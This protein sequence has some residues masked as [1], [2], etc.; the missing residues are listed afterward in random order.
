MDY[1][2]LTEFYESLEKTAKRL[3]KV[4]IIASLLETIQSDDLVVALNLIQGRVFPKTEEK[5]IG[6]SSQLMK[7]AIAKATGAAPESI[8]KLLIKTGD[9]GI[10]AEQLIKTKTQ[11]TLF[12]SRLTLN[13][14]YANITRLA[15]MEGEGTVNKKVSVIAELLTSAK[16]NEARFI[17]RTILENLRVGVAEGTMRDA[18]VWAFFAKELGIKYNRESNEVEIESREKYNEYAGAV[19]HLYDVTNDFVDV[20]KRLKQGGISALK[21]VEISLNKPINV[22]LYKKAE[23]IADAF[24]SVG[25]PCAL[26]YKYDGFRMLLIRNQDETRL[27]T[28]RL[29]NVTRQFPDV[30]RILRE[31]INSRSYVLDSEVIGIDPK[32]RKWLPFQQI[33]QR[34]RRKYNIEEMER[35]VPVMVN[36]FDAVKV[37]GK[38]LINEPFRKRR[39]IIEK[40]VHPVKDR[41]QPAHQIVTDNIKEAEKFYKKALKLGNEGIMA[42]NLEGIYKPG[43]RVGYGVKIKPTLES[44]DLVITRAEWGEGKRSSWFSS[45]TIS[46]RNGSEFLEI[47]RV[48]T[49]IKEL[50]QEENITFRQ[51]TRLL[52]PLIIEKQGKEVAI[53]PKIIVEVAYEEIQKSPKYSSGFALRFPRVAR[54]RIDKPLSEISDLD[55]VRHIYEKQ[56]HR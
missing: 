35:R 12:H 13:K 22:M 56:R 27:Y 30:V 37:D 43:S 42:K 38:D 41:L 1:I 40:I 5:K 54:M 47:G 17:T 15:G 8:E 16:P 9:L 45:F 19:Q 24:D 3:E 52:K 28:R 44:L 51:L 10:V 4:F 11:T 7:K 6:V 18:I 36:I 21:H 33:S 29:E 55:Y 49:G 14:V 34:I 46:C 39:E 53:K 26:E 50:E 25:K 32:T 20:V 31:N 48:G 2:K 23:N